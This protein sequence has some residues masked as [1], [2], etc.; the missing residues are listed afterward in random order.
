MVEHDLPV[1]LL[2][3]KLTEDLMERTS[4]FPRAVRQT[5]THRIES[6]AFA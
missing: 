6:R 2:W 3:E 5:L 4:K 1:F